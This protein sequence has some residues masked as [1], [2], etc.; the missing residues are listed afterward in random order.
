LNHA[1]NWFHRCSGVARGGRGGGGA[2]TLVRKNA[3]RGAPKAKNRGAEGAPLE[4]FSRP[5]QKRSPSYWKHN[6][7][8]FQ[9]HRFSIL[10]KIRAPTAPYF[11]Q[12]K[13][14]KSL[15]MSLLS[16]FMHSRELENQLWWRIRNDKFSAPSAPLIQ[17]CI[18]YFWSA[19]WKNEKW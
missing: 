13:I 18:H 7:P 12:Y 9:A 11:H 15:L 5:R 10:L 17:K 3:P 2:P 6:L 4:I 1:F 19:F 14:I 16:I 8:Y